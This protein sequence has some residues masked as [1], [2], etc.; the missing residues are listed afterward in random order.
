MKVIAILLWILG[1]Y[2]ICLLF[3]LCFTWLSFADVHVINNVAV[4]RSA[5]DVAFTALQFCATMALSVALPSRIS[6]VRQS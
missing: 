5:L 6:K 3:A 2:Q 1:F 4:A